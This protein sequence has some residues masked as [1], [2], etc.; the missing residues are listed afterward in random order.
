[1]PRKRAPHGPTDHLLA[2]LGRVISAPHQIETIKP[3]YYF[4]LKMVVRPEHRKFLGDTFR[5]IEASSN[6]PQALASIAEEIASWQDRE[7]PVR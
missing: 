7:F 4:S 3:D 5:E 2:L 1:M 6:S